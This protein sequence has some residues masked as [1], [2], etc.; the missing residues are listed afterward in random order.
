MSGNSILLDTNTIIYHLLGDPQ[1]KIV[2]DKRIVFIS[3]ITYA[4]LLANKNLTQAERTILNEYISL[5]NIIHTNDFICERAAYIR[6]KNKLKLPDA[7]IAATGIFLGIPLVT[8]DDGFSS[9]KDLQI[10]KLT[11]S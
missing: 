7:I 4:E 10:I 9:I 2:I 8:F 5:V 6:I 11:V 1:A 3:A